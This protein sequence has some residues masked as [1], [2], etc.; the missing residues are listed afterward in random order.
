MTHWWLSSP[1]KIWSNMH[2]TLALLKHQGLCSYH[3]SKENSTEPFWHLCS[4]HQNFDCLTSKHYARAYFLLFLR[5]PALDKDTTLCTGLLLFLFFLQKKILKTIFPDISIQKRSGPYRMW[6]VDSFLWAGWVM[7]AIYS[8]CGPV[9]VLVGLSYVFPSSRACPLS[10]RP[11]VL[12]Q[13]SGSTG[14]EQTGH[15]TKN[16][17]R[18][19]SSN[20][21][22]LSDTQHRESKL[23]G[24]PEL[25]SWGAGW[26]CWEY[27]LLLSRDLA[28][29]VC[30][31][32]YTEISGKHPSLNAHSATPPAGFLLLLFARWG[33]CNLLVWTMSHK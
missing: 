13:G 30:H 24:S 31:P 6:H 28:R 9:S 21:F 27:L 16:I 29:P 4:D 33:M 17:P 18:L 20:P 2:P 23:L 15:G 32:S 1:I 14:R 25:F 22:T 5:W 8:C 11:L 7:W 19:H 10:S 12:S 26:E 3:I